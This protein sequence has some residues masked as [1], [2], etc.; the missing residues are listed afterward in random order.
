MPT[1]PTPF[2]GL[3]AVYITHMHETC[4]KWVSTLYFFSQV[5][6]DVLLTYSLLSLV[7]EETN[8]LLYKGD[9]KLLSSLE[10]GL[11]VLA[12]SWSGDVLGPGLGGPVDVVDEGELIRS[13]F[14]QRYTRVRT[15][16]ESITRNA[17]IGQLGEPFPAFLRGKGSGH[18]VKGG[19]ELLSLGTGLGQLAADE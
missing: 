4:P 10:D 16:H 2:V 11:I 3:I 14:S 6:L 1:I 13:E 7:V 12:T 8:A 18:A 19:L 5:K 9:A 15:T 17:D